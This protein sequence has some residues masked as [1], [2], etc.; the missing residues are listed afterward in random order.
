MKNI[1]TILTLVLIAG[2]S[3]LIPHPWNFTAI[4]AMALFS[5]VRM[6]NRGL[7]F[8]APLLTLLWTDSLLGFHSTGIFVYAAVALITIIGFFIA[9]KKTQIVGA[10]I[11][12]SI[13]FFAL[14]N[15][16]VWL[17]QSLYPKNIPGLVE[18]F[19]MAIPFFGNQLVGD[20]F[21][22]GL[23][24]GIY[25]LLKAFVPSLDLAKSRS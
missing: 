5:G 10:S 24:F 17:T 15:F 16:G 22:T 11:A 7:A 13:L 20:L 18:C 23:M 21:Y 2:V 6:P 14:T 25:S 3:R 1:V 19:T 4:G 8:I 12:G 9:E